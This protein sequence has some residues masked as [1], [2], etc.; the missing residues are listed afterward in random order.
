MRL[1]RASQ[2]L[3]ED[4]RAL[5]SHGR[6]LGTGKIRADMQVPK[7]NCGCAKGSSGNPKAQV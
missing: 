3:G 2:A 6:C 7:G 5:G 1:R 4:L